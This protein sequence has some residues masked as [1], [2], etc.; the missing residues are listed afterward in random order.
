MALT[1]VAAALGKG[2]PASWPEAVERLRR[3]A[4][5][6][7]AFAEAQLDVLSQSGLEDASQPRASLQVL[8]ADPPIHSLP[9][10]LPKV[11]CDWLIS[12]ATGRLAKAQTY[13]GE[14]GGRRSNDVRNNS[15]VGFLIKDF[16]LVMIAVRARIAAAAGSSEDRLESPQVL[17]YA[18]GET[19]GPHHDFLDPRIAALKPE[20]AQ[21]GQRLATFLIYLNG[22]FE[23]G[24][25]QFPGLKL[26]YRGEP[27]DALLFANVDQTGAPDHRTLH[28][29]LP[30]RSGEKWLFSQWIRERR[31]F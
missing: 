24:E 18:P 3:A 14:T 23:G 20:L 21:N 30:P 19:F 25:T 29:G 6:G 13:D 7:S 9:G 2:E 22:E 8:L 27:G 28:A 4:K 10:F 1:A 5:L 26:T 16:D 12:R 31:G 15:M 11:V 17:H